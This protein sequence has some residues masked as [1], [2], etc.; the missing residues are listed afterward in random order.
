MSDQGAIVDGCISPPEIR[1]P[2]RS[3]F[4]DW[5]PETGQSCALN[6]RKNRPKER[7][8]DGTW[9]ECRGGRWTL[10]NPGAP[11]GP[12]SKAALNKLLAAQSVEGVTPSPAPGEAFATYRLKK[13]NGQTV[14]PRRSP[15]N[16]SRGGVCN[17]DD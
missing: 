3:R 15:P 4:S 2:C 9:H 13:P 6:S 12:A 1:D 7:L 16:R 10:A 14:A 17:E 11:I 8:A 5:I